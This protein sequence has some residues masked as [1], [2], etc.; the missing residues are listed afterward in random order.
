MCIRDRLHTDRCL[1]TGISKEQVEALLQGDIKDTEEDALKFALHYAETDQPPHLSEVETLKAVY[2][3]EK[4]R[5]ITT[6]L[7]LIFFGNLTGNTFDAFLSRLKGKPAQE[8]SILF[9]FFVF[10]IGIIPG[11]FLLIFTKK[12]RNT[13]FDFVVPKPIST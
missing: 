12:G 11:F 5:D 8:S 10:I 9:E 3:E 6:A 13:L 7:K 1:A 4:A 2:G